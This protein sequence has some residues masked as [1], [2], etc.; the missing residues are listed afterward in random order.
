M[1]QA[2]LARGLH[3]G[4]GAR[5]KAPVTELPV[6]CKPGRNAVPRRW[7][8]RG[9]LRPLKHLELAHLVELRHLKLPVRHRNPFPADAVPDRELLGV[10]ALADGDTCDTAHSSILADF[11]IGTDHAPEPACT[12]GRGERLGLQR[13]SDGSRAEPF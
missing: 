6:E 9:S 13:G 3:A 7:L 11:H 4:V 1:I 12:L 5:V 2:P 8:M 10:G